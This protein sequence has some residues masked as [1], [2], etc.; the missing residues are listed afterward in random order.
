MKQSLDSQ[1]NNPPDRALVVL[2]LGLVALD[3]A[4]VTLAVWAVDLVA[5]EW[6]EADDKSMSLM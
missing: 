5:V 3:L 6:A 1:D 2:A 4:A